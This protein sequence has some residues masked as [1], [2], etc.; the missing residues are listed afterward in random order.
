M[1]NDADASGFKKVYLA[2]GLGKHWGQTPVKNVE[3]YNDSFK[4]TVKDAI[5]VSKCGTQKE[6]QQNL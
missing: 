4:L 1:L 2:M 3:L 6:M 5:C